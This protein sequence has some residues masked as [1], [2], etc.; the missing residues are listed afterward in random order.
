VTEFVDQ[1]KSCRECNDSFIF[2]ASEQ[3]FFAEMGYTAPFR[4]RTCRSNRKSAKSSQQPTTAVA[5]ESAPAG[6]V[7]TRRPEPRSISYE[8]D[9]GDPKKR[10]N[11]RTR[12]QRMREEENDWGDY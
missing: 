12:K 2:S 6:A 8:T 3:K 9:H 5:M 10:K 7:E 4:C 11:R 1:E